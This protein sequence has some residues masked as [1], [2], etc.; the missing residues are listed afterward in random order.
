MTLTR[1]GREIAEY[2]DLAEGEGPPMESDG[3]ALR[4]RY[5]LVPSQPALTVRLRAAAGRVAEWRR[6]GLV[7]AWA[8]DPAIGQKLFNARSE[9]VDEKPS[10][11]S[12]FRRQRCLVVADGF[13]EWTPRS[14]DHRPHHFRPRQGTLLGLAGLYESW[15]GAD[16]ARIESCTVLTTEAGPDVR[17]VHG[18]MPVILRPESFAAW[19]DPESSASRLRPLLVPVPEG[20]LETRAVGRAVN[21]PRRDEPACLEPDPPASPGPLFEQRG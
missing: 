16:G 5:N 1:S 10:F 11:R 19:L 21:D 6:W 4:P 12:A 3:S 2:F 13:Y 8:K 20:S 9:T 14:R 17:P 18:R 7:P 15:S